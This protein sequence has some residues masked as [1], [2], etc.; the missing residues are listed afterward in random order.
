[1]ENMLEHRGNCN[2]NCI[3]KYCV[4]RFSDHKIQCSTQTGH[5]KY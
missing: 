5:L 1:M 3:G 4:D 2:C